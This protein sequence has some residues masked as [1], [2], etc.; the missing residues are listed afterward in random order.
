MDTRVTEL[1]RRPSAIV[2]LDSRRA[3]VARMAEGHPV[4]TQVDRYVEP[5]ADFLLRIIH[6]AAE[7][8]RL[9]VLGPEPA[10]L[11]LEREYVALYRRPDRLIDAGPELAPDRAELAD[12]LRLIDPVAPA[13]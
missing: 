9:V 11:A 8:D 10:R 7:C 2:W 1:K 3:L 6:E 4:V 12:R 13:A 5:E